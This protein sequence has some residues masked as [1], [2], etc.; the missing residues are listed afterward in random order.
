MSFLFA[1]LIV[2][3]WS[4]IF[5]FRIRFRHRQSRSFP[6]LWVSFVVSFFSYE[7]GYL[8]LNCR[9]SYSC[10]TDD[11]EDP[12]ACSSS[13]KL[14]ALLLVA[15]VGTRTYVKGTLTFLVSD[16]W[17]LRIKIIWYVTINPA[18]YSTQLIIKWTSKRLLLRSRLT[19]RS[20]I[21]NQVINNCSPFTDSTNRQPK[22]IITQ[23]NQVS[24]LW[25]RRPS[26]KHGTAGRVWP[27][28]KLELNMLLRLKS[29]WQES[30]D[31][32]EVIYLLCTV[33][34][35]DFASLKGWRPETASQN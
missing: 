15:F 4:Y 23:K 27:R 12:N 18:S 3:R 28:I 34:L 26:G 19:E 33:K 32:V 22:A 20:A 17:V 13:F 1:S 8:D 11:R 29:C 25:R 14:T 31:V 6:A 24:S 16:M 10:V 2:H 21:H 7:A 30:S 35:A 5:L 9:L